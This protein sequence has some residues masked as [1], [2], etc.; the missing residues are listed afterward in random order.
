MLIL[1]LELHLYFPTG[2]LRKTFFSPLVTLILFHIFHI[3]SHCCK[4][5]TPPTWNAPSSARWVS[6]GGCGGEQPESP[7]WRCVWGPEVD[8]E[9]SVLVWSVEKDSYQSCIVLFNPIA[10]LVLRTSLP[11][12]VQSGCSRAESEMTGKD[13]G[14]AVRERLCRAGRVWWGMHTGVEAKEMAA[15]MERLKLM[16]CKDM[17]RRREA[18]EFPYG[19]SF[20]SSSWSLHSSERCIHGG[21]G[22]R[23]T[24][25]NLLAVLF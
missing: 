8:A 21:G 19:V 12:W 2:N 10:S 11:T 14:V 13:A 4:I 9:G 17:P 22:G 23:K 15:A 5:F 20:C 6:S 3:S 1:I 7:D 16:A 18:K 24:K 25:L